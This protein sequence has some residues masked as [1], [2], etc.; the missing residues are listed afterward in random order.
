MSVESCTRRLSLIEHAAPAFSAIAGGLAESPRVVRSVSL[1]ASV[2]RGEAG[3]LA[4]ERIVAD[5]FVNGCWAAMTGQ[6]NRV[7]WQGE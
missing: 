6:H 7:G 4:H 5:L 2:I 1:A 3:W